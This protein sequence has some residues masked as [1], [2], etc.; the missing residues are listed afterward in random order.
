MGNTLDGAHKIACGHADTDELRKSL[1]CDRLS[2]PIAEM[3]D[4]IQFLQ[5]HTQRLQQ[6]AERDAQQPAPTLGSTGREPMVLVA[7]GYCILFGYQTPSRTPTDLDFE[8]AFQAALKRPQDLL[9]EMIALRAQEV[10]KEKVTRLMKMTKKAQLDPKTFCGPQGEALRH[11]AV[12]LRAA[13]ECAEI[14]SEIREMSSMGKFNQQEAQQLLHGTESDQRSMMA[15]M[16]V[17][18]CHQDNMYR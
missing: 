8:R 16:G 5:S 9:E 17:P 6:L 11:M 14:Y 3:V 1:L 2:T 12:F 7:A 15:V 18:S 10:P 4:A 13:V